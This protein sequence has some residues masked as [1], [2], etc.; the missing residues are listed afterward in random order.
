MYFV[1]DIINFVF[2]VWRLKVEMK[3]RTETAKMFLKKF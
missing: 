2:I 3:S 1:S